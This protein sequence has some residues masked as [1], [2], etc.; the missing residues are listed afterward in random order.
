M[1]IRFKRGMGDVLNTD[2]VVGA[3]TAATDASTPG[4]FD[5]SCPPGSPGCVP[6]WYCYIPFMATPD[7]LASFSQGVKEGA[8]AV[9]SAAGSVA[10]S[11]V[12]GTVAGVAQGIEDTLLPGSSS[13]NWALYLGLAGIA[14][15]ALIVFGGGSSR[16]YGR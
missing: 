13:T 6:H 15:F 14:A 3:T 12:S 2:L 1:A 9:G 5:S 16:R 11:A 10:A 4:F 8:T 7:C